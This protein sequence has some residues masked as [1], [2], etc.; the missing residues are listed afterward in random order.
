MSLTNFRRLLPALATFFP[1]FCTGEIP[2]PIPRS[3]A[4]Q[5]REFIL[6]DYFG[7]EWP[8]QVLQQALR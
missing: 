3:E 6:R 1:V 5:T 7:A 2:A 4:L 8:E